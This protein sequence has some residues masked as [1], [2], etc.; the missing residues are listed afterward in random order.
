MDNHVIDKIGNYTK[1]KGLC[2][3]IIRLT[4]S[5]PNVNHK[6]KD[7]FN[8][9]FS[10]SELALEYLIKVY[11]TDIKG[12]NEE[13]ELYFDGGCECA[14]LRCQSK[15]EFIRFMKT[16]QTAGYISCFI[17]NP[18]VSQYY[19]EM[20]VMFA[21]KALDPNPTHDG[22]LTKYFSQEWFKNSYSPDMND[23][24]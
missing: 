2:N 1:P 17:R 22:N 20:H 16:S 3:M 6:S 23:F 13:S 14:P 5:D 21:G 11:E 15:E 10:K 8:G 19:K 4:N 9:M 18:V 12:Y 24:Q 7:I